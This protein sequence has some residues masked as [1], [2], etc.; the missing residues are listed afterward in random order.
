MALARKAKQKKAAEDRANW[1]R[2]KTARMRA[3]RAAFESAKLAKAER[4]AL[5]RE[6]AAQSYDVWLERKQEQEYLAHEA[7]IAGPSA[8]H[9]ATM[10]EIRVLRK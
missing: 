4:V 8:P 2:S 3:E 6:Q 9:G 10:N 7:A 5:R 1:V